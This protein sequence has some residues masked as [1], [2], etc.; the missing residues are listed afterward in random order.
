MVI[1]VLHKSVVWLEEEMFKIC[2]YPEYNIIRSMVISI[3]NSPRYM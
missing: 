3:Y 1:D 2:I